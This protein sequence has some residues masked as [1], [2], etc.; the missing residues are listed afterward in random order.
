MNVSE[1]MLELVRSIVF[2]SGIEKKKLQGIKESI[3]GEMLEALYKLSKAHDID[4]LVGAALQKYA[5]IAP[6]DS[7]ISSKLCKSKLVAAFRCDKI[8]RETT[9]ILDTLEKAEFD[10]IP[11]KGAVIRKLYPEEWMRTSCDID[12]LVRK[13][14]LDAAIECLKSK[15]GYTAEDLKSGHDISLY[16]KNNIHIELHFT[17]EEKIEK[18]NGVL[19]SVWDNVYLVEGKSHRYRLTNEFLLFHV[20]SHAAKHFV[21]GGCGV[22]C[23]IDMMLIKN[24]LQLD[25]IYFDDLIN[26]SGLS[27]FAMVCDR[28]CKLWFEKAKV[29]DKSNKDF[30][31]VVEEYVLC[32]GVYGSKSN[33]IKLTRKN[34]KKS[35]ALS[36]IF[37]PYYLL[38]ERYPILVDHKYLFPIFQVVRW[39]SLLDG[40]RFKR[41]RKE[42]QINN[43]IKDDQ[44][45]KS[46]EMI[47]WLGLN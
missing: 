10:H 28:L 31:Y 19:S 46:H 6:N 14:D 13:E 4:N 39:F 35:Y 27:S 8:E 36:R 18:V 26:R 21:Y 33:R 40:K 11:L 7:E 37:M 22:R 5:L 44:V 32:G 15:L 17:L 25:S 24:Q 43:S 47:L 45:Q 16:S 42:V 3:N 9:L 12:V 29:T 34:T 30:I 1:I 23:F 38:K 41:I 20:I 2:E